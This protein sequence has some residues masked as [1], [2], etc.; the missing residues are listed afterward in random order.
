[1]FTC[2]NVATCCDGFEAKGMSDNYIQCVPSEWSR[3]V[4]CPQLPQSTTAFRG[5]DSAVVSAETTAAPVTPV[6]SGAMLVK[7]TL[8]TSGATLVK[9]T[10]GLAAI[11]GIIVAGQS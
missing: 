6:A 5:K 8:V 9:G 4:T 1:M 7:D 10:V 11:V 2:A 3:Q